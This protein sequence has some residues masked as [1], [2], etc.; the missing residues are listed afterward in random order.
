MEINEKAPDGWKGTV[1][2]MLTKHKDKFD[3]DADS[4]K[5]KKD[6][7]DGEDKKDK[8]D[9]KINPFALA[10]SMKKKGDEPHYKDQESTKKG[11]PEKKE[12]FKDEDKKEKDKDDDKEEEKSESV[13]LWQQWR[14]IRESNS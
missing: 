4:K 5:D 12:K 13:S 1:R 11:K 2:A 10:N 9:G 14:T 7:K 6:D 3:K 8:K